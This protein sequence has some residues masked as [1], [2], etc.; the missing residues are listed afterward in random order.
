MADN[1]YKTIKPVESL[2]NIAGL[3]PAKRREE[4]KRRQNLPTDH[5]EERESTEGGL[6][7]SVEP[8]NHDSELT[9]DE[10]DRHSVDY[11]A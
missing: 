11:C 8:E 2:Q 1:D 7:E 5:K 9:D 4:R 10:N 3:T 6:N